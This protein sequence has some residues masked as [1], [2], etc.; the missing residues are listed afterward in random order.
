LRVHIKN[1][2]LFM[3]VRP[4]FFISTGLIMTVTYLYNYKI[5]I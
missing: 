3:S 5:I 2:F 1:L 4:F